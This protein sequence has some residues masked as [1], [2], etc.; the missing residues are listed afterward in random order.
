MAVF[1][2]SES[3][4]ESEKK[5]HTQELASLQALHQHELH[6]LT[7]RHQQEIRQLEEQVDQLQQLNPQNSSMTNYRTEELEE[8]NLGM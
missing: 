6:S 5:Q 2:D 7:L 4:L 1:Q 8:L 3:P